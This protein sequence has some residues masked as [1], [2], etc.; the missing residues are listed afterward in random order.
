M[1]EGSMYL[2][3]FFWAPALEAAHANSPTLLPYG[4]IFASFM[5]SMMTASLLF[6]KLSSYTTLSHGTLLSA[7]LAVSTVTFYTLYSAPR[8]EQTAFWLF[9]AFEA[10]VGVYWPVVGLLKGKVVDDAVRA[11]VY[12]VLRVPLN[13]FVVAS[14]ALTRG[15]GDYAKVFGACAAFLL[16]GA[17]AV[18]LTIA[19]S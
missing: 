12:G 9:C 13:V 2:F 10:C 17:G 7:L 4:T 5:A 15:G 8:T 1:F 6:T 11:Q 19:G 3:V 16:A 14:L 18:A